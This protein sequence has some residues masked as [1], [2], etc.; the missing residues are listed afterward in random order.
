MAYQASTATTPNVPHL[1]GSQPIAGPRQWAYVSTH[2]RAECTA[3]NFFTDALD[4]G[5]KVG[6]SMYVWESSSNSLAD[7]IRMSHHNWTVVSATASELGVGHLISSA[8]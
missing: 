8:S 2:T 7:T 1:M 5:I 6:D 3:A 4:L